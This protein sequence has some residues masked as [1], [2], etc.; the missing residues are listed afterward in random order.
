[1]CGPLMKML[2]AIR[3][4]T[5]TAGLP[6]RSKLDYAMESMRKCG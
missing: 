4:D 1:M 6:L 3:C 2:R 5:R